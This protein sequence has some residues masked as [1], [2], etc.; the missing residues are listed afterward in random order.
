M[1]AQ[2]QPDRYTVEHTG[3]I[4]RSHMHRSIDMT[5]EDRSIFV[6]PNDGTVL[7]NPIGGRAEFP[8]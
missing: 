2:F 4:E 8:V 1:V 3:N 7:M 6:G 5:T